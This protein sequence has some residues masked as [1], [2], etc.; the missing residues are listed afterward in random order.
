VLEAVE[1]LPVKFRLWM[2]GPVPA[3]SAWSWDAD[4]AGLIDPITGHPLNAAGGSC[5]DTPGPYAPIPPA[6][7]VSA[8]SGGTTAVLV[9]DRPVTATGSTPDDAIT[10]NGMTA[11]SASNVD[12]TT[13]SFATPGPGLGG[14]TP[15]VISRQPDWIS[16]AVQ[17]PSSGTL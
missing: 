16:Q 3:A 1:M 5:A 4:G 17:W 15:W 2:S 8:Y 14:A 9:F 6:A 10:F 7:V 13:L 12:A 11:V